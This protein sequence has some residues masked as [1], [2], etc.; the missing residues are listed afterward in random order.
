M[1]PDG[2]KLR[3]LDDLGEKN[4][5]AIKAGPFGSALKKEFYVKAGYKIYGQEQVIANDYDY[6]N[7]Y[8]DEEKYLSLKSCAIKPGDIL[9][10]LVGTVGK[11]LLMGQ[12]C[13][14]GVINPRLLRISTSQNLLDSLFLK[15][16]LESE[17]TA[18]TLQSWAQGG[19]MG[20]LNA[21][22][23][24]RLP[25]LCPPLPEQKKIA[26]I[27]STWDKAITTTEQ[28]LANSQQ[29]KKALMQQ[30]LTG[31]KRLLDENG[32]RFSGKW[33]N[34]S[35]GEFSQITTGTSK[36]K[37][38]SK[39]GHNYIIDMGSITREGKLLPSKRTDIKSDFLK[40]GQLVM[41][42]DDIGGGNIIGK[43]GMID[44]NNKYIL[45]DHVYALKIINHDSLFI[46]Y[47]INSH[48]INKS[49][50]RKANGTA[51]L[52]LSKK[53]VLK[54]N[55]YMPSDINEQQKIASVLSAADK[56]ISALQQ[57]LDMLKQEKKTLMQ[58]LLTGKRRVKVEEA[59]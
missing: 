43:V 16:F 51:Q 39:T 36:S 10:S 24:K 58:Q 8:I 46:S 55:I 56:E 11:V 40:A 33:R 18:N 45:A 31:K 34:Y 2:W 47:I 37:F 35:L 32:V 28:L 1:V 54:Q 25:I 48:C 44:R 14:P 15:Y 9:I 19:T 26:Q 3:K 13:Q 49:I 23:I 21:E 4:K 27:F 7:Y 53:D 30:L 52:G 6:G 29:Q 41:P 57:K 38:I 5:P 42:K 12:D 50:R 20:V 22:M 59:I 17:N